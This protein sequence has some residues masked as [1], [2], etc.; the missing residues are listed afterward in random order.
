MLPLF[1]HSFPSLYNNSQLVIAYS[2]LPKERR[3]AFEAEVRENASMCKG[4]DL[5]QE[6]DT[7]V[8]EI[9]RKIFQKMAFV[10]PIKTVDSMD[11]ESYLSPSPVHVAWYIHGLIHRSHPVHMQDTTYRP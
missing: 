4:S 1:L 2:W 9:E 3:K 5:R 6:K 11:A 10:S 7:C 8:C